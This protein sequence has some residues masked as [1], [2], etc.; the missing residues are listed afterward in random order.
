[1][2]LVFPFEV[3]LELFEI[4]K[5]N[6]KWGTPIP[7]AYNNENYSCGHGTLTPD[8]KVMYFVSDMPGGLGG[9]D[10]YRIKKKSGIKYD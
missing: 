10:I 2:K 7:L 4:S 3:V 1:M 8:G 5:E 6:G 9:T